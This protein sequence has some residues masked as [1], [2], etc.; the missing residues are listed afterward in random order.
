PVRL[1]LL[2]TTPAPEVSFTVSATSSAAEADPDAHPN[3]VEVTRAALEV[4][5][6]IEGTVRDT[7]GAPVTELTVWLYRVGESTNA[8]SAMT[9]AEGLYRF[10]DVDAG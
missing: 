2:Y 7:A 6:T 8:L 4:P 3:S 10:S 1:G 9:D 5:A